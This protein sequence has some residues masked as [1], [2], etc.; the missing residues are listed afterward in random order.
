MDDANQL[1]ALQRYL[2]D[3]FHIRTSFMDFQMFQARVGKSYYHIKRPLFVLLNDYNNTRDELT[4]QVSAWLA[5]EYPTWLLF[6]RNDTRMEDFFRNI[7]VPFDCKLMVTRDRGNGTGETIVEVYQIDKESEIRVMHFGFWN[8]TAGFKGPTTGL[9]QRRNNLH[10]RRSYV[11]HHSHRLTYLESESWGVNLPNG[12]WTGVIGMLVRN[13]A[14]IAATGLMM[15]SDRLDAIAFT[16]AVYATKYRA[17]IK[18]PASTSIKWQAYTAPFDAYIWYAIGLL[19]L[20]SSAMI[21]MIKI[22]VK[23]VSYYK[24]FEHSPSTFTEIIL[25]VFGAFCNQGMQ[26]S[27]LDPVRVVQ[28]CI[29]LTAVVVVAAYSAALISFLAIKT[30]VMPFTTMEG[31]LKDGTY[32]FA[33]IRDSADYSFYQNTTDKVL[34]ILFD[35]VL[36]KEDHLPAN[37][38]DG[39]RRVCEEDKYAFMAMDNTAS[40]LQRKLACRLEPLDTITQTSIAMATPVRNPYR[41]I[42]NT[43]IL[44]L[45]DSG[46]LQR[47]LNTEWSN[48]FSKPK[49]TWTSVEFGDMVPLLVVMFCGSVLSSF[50]LSLEGRESE[51]KLCIYFSLNERIR[52]LDLGEINNSR[53]SPCCYFVWGMM[54]STK[55]SAKE[56][57]MGKENICVSKQSNKLAGT[58]SQ[59][60]LPRR[61]FFSADLEGRCSCNCDANPINN[62][63]FNEFKSSA[64]KTPFRIHFDRAGNDLDKG[65]RFRERIVEYDTRRI[66]E[67][68]KNARVSESKIE[69]KDELTS[70][71]RTSLIRKRQPEA[72]LVQ[73]RLQN[74]KDS[75]A[76]VRN[77]VDPNDNRITRSIKSNSGL[78]LPSRQISTAKSLID[79]SKVN[80]PST[81]TSKVYDG[82]KRNSVKST[83]AERSLANKRSLS[84]VSINKPNNLADG[85]NRAHTRSR[86]CSNQRRV[87]P[88]GNKVTSIGSAN[89]SSINVQKPQIGFDKCKKLGGSKESLVSR[90]LIVLTSDSPKRQIAE[91]VEDYRIPETTKG[92]SSSNCKVT[93]ASRKQ[94][95]IDREE[96][97]LV[98]AIP[99]KVQAKIENELQVIKQNTDFSAY[100]LYHADYLVDLLTIEKQKEASS[101]KLSSEFLNQYINSESR[102]LIVTFLIRLSSHCRYPSFI[103]Y[104]AIKLFDITLDRIP[105]EDTDMQLIAITALWIVLKKDGNFNKIPSARSMLALVQELQ[106][107]NV[108]RLAESERLI[109]C[110]L[111]F[112]I[113]FSDPFSIFVFYVINYD[114]DPGVSHG[115]ITKIYY[116]GGYVIDLTLLDAKFCYVTS[117]HLALATAELVMCVILD[118]EVNLSSPRW[119]FWRQV[120]TNGVHVPI[121]YYDDEINLLR[122]TMIDHIL[123]SAKKHTKE[124][125]VRKRY[126]HSRYGNVSEFFIDKIKKIP[127]TESTRYVCSV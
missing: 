59:K 62:V 72:K 108:D 44:M 61:R 7:Y 53:C 4:H 103:L 75:K 64:R 52:L 26:Q 8:K 41:G 10:G 56:K 89:E 1:L 70:W 45:R 122:A 84:S 92:L 43:N 88:A 77:L 95:L 118:D 115:I 98:D 3:T 14:D 73:D 79:L 126:S 35:Q 20:L 119:H 93:S 101:P 18:R 57:A 96:E 24:D 127:Q 39:L 9:Y 83:S 51:I 91:T 113:T 105:M 90:P 114:Y 21:S 2:S 16:S 111:D 97:P 58:K 68:K 31:L 87:V 76:I 6:F 32:R 109:L 67:F 19:I 29:H 30:F 60:I 12:S 107:D 38:L 110:T 42:I 124:T 116:C 28:F 80:K 27:L 120:I 63:V 81:L 11:C 69:K 34:S 55:L 40:D 47:L 106:N 78:N 37:Y 125:V 71:H 50:L 54:S 99:E 112:N 117:N 85:W 5:M 123:E 65:S 15:T 74:F 102:K 23:M 86:S 100:L 48:R 104:Q 66:G 36:A 121:K 22:T 49:S 94:K 17:F 46:I 13:E 25:Y 82:V 33:V